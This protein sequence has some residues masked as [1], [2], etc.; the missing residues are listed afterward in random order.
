MPFWPVYAASVLC[1][2]LWTVL[3][4]D[5]PI[6]PRRVDFFRKDRSFT[7]ERARAELGYEPQVDLEEGLQQTH[8]WYLAQGLL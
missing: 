1:Q 7:G 3:P 4:G 2:A 8:D 6:Y 5:P